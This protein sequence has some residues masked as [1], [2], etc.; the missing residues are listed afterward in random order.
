MAEEVNADKKKAAMIIIKD[1]REILD[2]ETY[3]KVVALVAL[4]QEHTSDLM[5]E[6]FKSRVS[7]MFGLSAIE[8]LLND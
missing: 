1:L 6:A 7:N 5:Q 2:A 3:A 8:E 4:T